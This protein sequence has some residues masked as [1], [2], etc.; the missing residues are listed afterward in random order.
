MS[1]YNV[2]F[3][4]W[5]KPSFS[6]LFATFV[7][8]SFLLIFIFLQ[9]PI[10]ILYTFLRLQSCSIVSSYQIYLFMVHLVSSRP[11][12]FWEH[13]VSHQFMD[14]RIHLFLR[15]HSSTIFQELFLYSSSL[16]S[17]A[18]SYYGIQYLWNSK[19]QVHV[20]KLLQSCYSA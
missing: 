17:F 19:E 3:V 18:S 10:L 15:A 13:T 14:L 16:C 20:T 8:V 6:S 1:D 7:F 9:L 4:H 5:Q 11:S 2:N 12:H